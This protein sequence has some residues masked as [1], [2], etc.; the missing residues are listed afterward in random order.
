[1]TCIINNQFINYEIINL[2]IG[3]SMTNLSQLVFKILNINF[4][5]FP[6]D[7]VETKWYQ[8]FVRSY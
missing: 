5:F 2:S 4:V 6:M 8:T 7:V 1:M 3:Q